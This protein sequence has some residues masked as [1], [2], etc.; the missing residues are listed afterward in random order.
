MKC[1]IHDIKK[2]LVTDEVFDEQSQLEIFKYDIPKFSIRYP[3]VISKEKR[4][5]QHELERKLKI[6]E[7]S[8]SCDKNIEEYHK[9]KADLDGIYDN[10]AEGVKIRSKC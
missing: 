9:C 5:K 7:K 8:L 3:K 6:L 2:K 4:K 1:F 10:N